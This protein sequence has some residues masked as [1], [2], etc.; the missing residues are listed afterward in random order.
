MRNMYRIALVGLAMAIVLTSAGRIP[1]QEDRAR[2]RDRD[3]ASAER[4]APRARSDSPP[5]ERRERGGGEQDRRE[6]RVRPPADENAE[7]TEEGMPAARVAPQVQP[8]G[9]IAPPF[10]LPQRW[11]LGVFAVNTETGVLITRV[12][13]GTPAWRAGVEPRDH[14]V[15]V[16][17]YQIGFVNGRL[18]PLGDELQHRADRAGRVA[19]L[20]QDTRTG[21]LVNMPVQLERYG[22][23]PRPLR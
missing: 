20:V 10:I 5:A 18:Y 2:D 8:G 13:P 3:T 1:A 12:I 7:G 19:L 22:A 16:G 14:I 15:C 17:G 4:E 11:R 23:F 9:R 21:D 6:G